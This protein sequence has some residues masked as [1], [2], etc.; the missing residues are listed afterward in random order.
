VFDGSSSQLVLRA[1][2]S[3]RASREELHA[4]RGLLNKLDKDAPCWTHC[5]SSLGVSDLVRPRSESGGKPYS[6]R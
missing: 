1:L 6:R 4:I 5:R 3:Q 2:G